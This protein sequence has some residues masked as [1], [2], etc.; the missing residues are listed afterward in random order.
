MCN[1]ST[2]HTT[3]HQPAGVAIFFACVMTKRILDAESD[4]DLIGRSNHRFPP[5]VTWRFAVPQQS[6]QP[7]KNN[8]KHKAVLSPGI[9]QFVILS[10]TEYTLRAALY[11]LWCMS[12]KGS[13]SFQPPGLTVL[14]GRLRGSLTFPMTSTIETVYSL[15]RR[16]THSPYT[17]RA[18]GERVGN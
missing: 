6:K 7:F 1:C 10:C 14:T 2:S 18:V 5:Q 8:H 17:K 12:E 4:L 3:T 16:G 11:D 13:T 15:T 9:V